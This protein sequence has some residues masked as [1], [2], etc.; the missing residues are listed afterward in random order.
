MLKKM[1]SKKI[2]VTLASIFA[3]FLI[4]L[5]PKDTTSTIGSIPTNLEYINENKITST[6]YL[7]TN[8]G[9]LGKAQILSSK[10]LTI[11]EEAKELLGVLIRGGEKESKIPN[12]FQAVLPS[13]TKILSIHYENHVLKVNLSKEVLDV[14]KEQEEQVIEAIIY[15]LTSI[16]DVEKIIL[17]KEGDILDKL[18]QTG[19]TLPST[20]DRSFG[21]NKE[22]EFTSLSDINM[23]T[24]YYID[25]YN[26]HYYYVPVTKYLNDDREKIKIIIDELASSSTKNT[27]LM[28]FLNSNTKLL[29]AEL[30]EKEL[31]LEFNSYLFQDAEEKNIL[32]EVIYT[33][34]LSVKDNYD[35]EEVTF[36]VENEEI[37]KTVLKTIE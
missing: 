22:Y 24:V 4:Y 35:V 36:Q 12:G 32:E 7:L 31:N 13:E 29:A 21:I 26:D 11:E 8:S 3:L 25:Q 15:T 28:S 1:A 20:L 10:E 18:P 16:Q 19:I 6:A 14:K 37:Q 5:I 30:T 2:M 27:S 33:I 34:A 23:V 9:L 17:Y